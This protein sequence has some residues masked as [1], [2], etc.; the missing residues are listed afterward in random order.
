MSM[1]LVVFRI[2][3]CSRI[4]SIRIPVDSRLPLIHVRNRELTD[5]SMGEY[6]EVPIIRN[7]RQKIVVP[8]ISELKGFYCS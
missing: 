8:K 1:S 2:C 7:S 6:Y 3:Y 4:P 5:N